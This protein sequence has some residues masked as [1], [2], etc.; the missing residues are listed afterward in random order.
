MKTLHTPALDLHLLQCLDLLLQEANV[1]RAA[2]RADVTQSAM[3]HALRRL[4]LHFADPLLVRAGRGMKLS[5][6]G[7]AL[8]APLR[9]ALLQ[10]HRVAQTQESFDPSRGAHQFRMLMPDYGDMVLVPPLMR[11]LSEKAPQSSLHCLQ[12]GGLDWLA[13]SAQ[14]DVLIG[15]FDQA[16]QSAH[17]RDL[18]EEDFVLIASAR[19]PRLGQ[20]APDLEAYLAESHI[21]VR[22]T[23]LGRGQV[24][25]WLHERGHSRHI[26]CT[27]AQFSSAGR[28]VAQSDLICTLPRR[29][30]QALAVDHDLSL[31]QLPLALPSFQ[32]RM[33]WSPALHHEARHRWFREEIIT[34]LRERLAEL[35]A[36]ARSRAR[37][38]HQSAKS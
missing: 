31:H 18:W 6:R 16:P 7:L 12:D 2:L 8:R 4:R 17:Q 29:V 22:L 11:R 30:A 5:A 14:A 15:R 36:I 10:L 24:D 9:E 23:G 32:V 34:A 21:Q 35:D 20:Q 3:S 1:S 19:H 38:P 27:F 13:A 26:A 37:R 28:L 25:Q 33:L